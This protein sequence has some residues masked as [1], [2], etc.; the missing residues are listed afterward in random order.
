MKIEDW[1]RQNEIRAANRAKYWEE[2]RRAHAEFRSP[3][4][5]PAPEA[6][7]P[8]E[9][10]CECGAEKLGHPKGDVGHSVWCAW[11]RS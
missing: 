5:L 8:L 6:S 4:V 10:K 11:R 9:S 1:A 3:D 2:V 7:G